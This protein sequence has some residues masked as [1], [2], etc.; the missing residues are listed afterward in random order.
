VASNVTGR[1]MRVL[2]LVCGVDQVWHVD[3]GK[4]LEVRQV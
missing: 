3:D 1:N 4:E 2:V